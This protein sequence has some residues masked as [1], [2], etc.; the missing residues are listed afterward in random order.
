M[1]KIESVLGKKLKAKWHDKY[2]LKPGFNFIIGCK[3]FFT[4]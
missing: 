3:K 1:T 2:M 4:L